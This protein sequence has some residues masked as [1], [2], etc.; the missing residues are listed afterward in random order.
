MSLSLFLYYL[1]YFPITKPSPPPSTRTLPGAPSVGQGLVISLE[2]GLSVRSLPES[3]A[4]TVR[5]GNCVI[6][7]C[8]EGSGERR[9]RGRHLTALKHLRC[10]LV[11]G[12]DFFILRNQ[13]KDIFCYNFLTKDRK[14]SNFS[15]FNRTM[16]QDVNP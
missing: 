14:L 6:S 11:R 1:Y 2:R 7:G 8:G 10:R 13:K 16:F 15:D 5:P 3:C 12:V 9:G 4:R